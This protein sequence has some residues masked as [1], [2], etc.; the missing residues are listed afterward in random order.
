MKCPYC[1]SIENKV[2]DSRLTE[3]SDTI[4]RRRQCLDCDQRFT[5][6]ER[7]E[8]IPITVIKR[9]G[10]RQPFERNKILNGLI[11]ACVKRQI[12][13]TLLDDMVTDIE[14]EIRSQFKY[15][16][17][18][19]ELGEMVLERLKTFDKVAYVRFA[20]VYRYFEDIKQFS[21][22]LEKLE[23]RSKNKKSAQVQGGNGGK[24][25]QQVNELQEPD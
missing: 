14:N 15:E 8:E 4:R 5:T 16:I 25:N 9:N 19:Q 12:S 21:E 18:S 1:F 23:S 24:S 17:S 11:R 3:S 13:I 6:Y 20:S 22:E 2:I 10:E 7:V